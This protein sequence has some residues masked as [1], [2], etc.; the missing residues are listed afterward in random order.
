MMNLMKIFRECRYLKPFV[1]LNILFL[2]MNFSGKFAIEMY[3]LDILETTKSSLGPFS[4]IIL[5][6]WVGKLDSNLARHR[7]HCRDCQP[8]RVSSIPTCG[9]TGLEKEHSDQ[10]ISSHEPGTGHPW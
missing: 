1:I 10:F 2:L 4:A 3:A 7:N 8:P 6:G 5:L 9:Q